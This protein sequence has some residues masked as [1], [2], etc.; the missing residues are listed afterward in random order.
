MDR[1]SRRNARRRAVQRASWPPCGGPRGSLPALESPYISQPQRQRGI[2]PL[3]L[4]LSSL[5]QESTDLYQAKLF[6]GS[7]TVILLPRLL[8]SPWG[9]S[10]VPSLPD[11]SPTEPRP[12]LHLTVH[13]IQGP[14]GS[15][16]AD[17]GWNQEQRDSDIS[18]SQNLL[19]KVS[20]VYRLILKT[21]KSWQT[22]Q[23]FKKP[24]WSPNICGF[25]EFEIFHNKIEIIFKK[26]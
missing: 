9:T 24:L 21:S 12:H 8:S 17:T 26:Y 16:K 19:W 1:R 5:L 23:K 22:G 6:P 15:N 10:P 11:R 2:S 13:W 25:C 14:F 18:P 4:S 7:A 20:S 3:A